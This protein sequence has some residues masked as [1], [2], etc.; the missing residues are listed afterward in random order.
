MKLIELNKANAWQIGTGDGS[1][2]YSWLFFKYGVAVVGPGDPGEEGSESAMQYY[3]ANPTHTNWG[4]VLNGVKEGDWL[5]ARPGTGRITGV[6]RVTG[7][8]RYG[9][10]FDDV[11]GWDLQHYVP[12][13]W[14]RPAGGDHV[15]QLSRNCLT[16]ATLQG[17]KLDEVFDAIRATDFERAP[18]DVDVNTLTDPQDADVEEI[19]D[20]L[21]DKGVR[22]QDAEDVVQ[23]VR[24][25]IRLTSWY[26][27]H[28]RDVLEHE[29]RAFL[30]LPLLGALGWSEQ[31]TKLEY[32]NVDVALFEAA[33][34]MAVKQEPVMLVE[35]KVFGN[36]LA[37]TVD[38]LATY[39][40]KFPKCERFVTTNGYRYR[41]YVRDGDRLVPHGHVNLLN[42]R[43]Q[44]V[45]EP[46]LLS[47]LFTLIALSNF[48]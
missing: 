21:V 32:Q 18:A 13:E 47:P 27:A 37:Y 45:L 39:A 3:A 41:T 46:E 29:I 25:I 16:R 6:G 4:G 26:Y 7:P 23:T 31:C 30:V 22:I 10:F 40:A 12:V 28:D 19:G 20:L 1:R 14:Y 44:N 17:C 2:S 42:L 48:N 35:A 8:M 34:Q 15:L 43:K 5:I 38:Q 11:E 9:R 33:F 24:R 36:G